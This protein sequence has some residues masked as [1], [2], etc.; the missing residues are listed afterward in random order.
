V[1]I[2]NPHRTELSG[3][4]FLNPALDK[5]LLALQAWGHLEHN[6]DGTHGDVTANSV[7]VTENLDANGVE[8][9][10]LPTADS[11]LATG[12]LLGTQWKIVESTEDTPGAGN[13]T[14][15]QIWDVLNGGSAPALRLVW[16]TDHWVLFHGQGQTSG[17][18]FGTSSR[19]IDAMHVLTQTVITA[20]NSLGTNTLGT[21]SATSLTMSG[22]EIVT[23]VINP[24]QLV[25]NTNNWNPTGLSTA[26]LI[27]L[28]TDASR[29]ITGLVA[30]STG[31]LVT[32][33]NGGAFDAVL[34][35][36]DANSTAANRFITPGLADLTLTPGSSA[37]FYYDGVSS[38]WRFWS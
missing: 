15:L 25:A 30:Q 28:G 21:T 20:L 1:I 38:L 23:G 17:L 35:Y 34:K 29:N 36:N 18:E 9:G 26:R 24:T 13:G 19:R 12:I 8:V 27:I 32:L 16:V 37:T 6:E 10:T 3:I 5:V 4:P 33:M 11:D 14:E 31:R 7:T 22:P 2:R